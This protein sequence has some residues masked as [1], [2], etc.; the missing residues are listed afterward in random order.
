MAE[1][2]TLTVL[3]TDV[4]DFLDEASASFWSNAQLNRYINRAADR[5]WARVRALNDEYFTITR[6]STDGAL[7][8]L[9]ESYTASSFA[10][11]AG[12]RDYSLPPDFEEMKAIE[13]LTDNYEDVRFVYRDLSDPDM[14]ALLEITDNQTPSTF[15]FS[16]I[17]TRT[18]RIA[19]LSD[20]ALDLRLTYVRRF[21][22][23]TTDADTLTMPHPLY[24]A[25]ENYATAFALRQDRSP[26]AVTFA[27][28]GDKVIA[29]MFGGHHRQSQDPET[30]VGYLADWTGW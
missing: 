30:V 20:T 24:L 6:D 27:Q 4:R 14:R 25:V 22:E 7:T 29:E 2:K 26:D 9:G 13:V 28:D 17:G 15:L 18:M 1:L 11:V 12:T 19:P 16:L 8:I 10:I 3:R 5:V 21:A 23:M